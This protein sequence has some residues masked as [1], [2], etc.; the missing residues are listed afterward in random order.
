M[1]QTPVALGEF[2][3]LALQLFGQRLRLRQK[4]LRAHGGGDGVQH[5]AHAL[6]ELIEERQV[7][8]AEMMERSQLDHR[9]HFALRRAP[10]GPRCPAAWLRPDRS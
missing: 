7:D 10:A 6:G 3:L 4:L 8:I 2:F 1:L 5:D 9:F